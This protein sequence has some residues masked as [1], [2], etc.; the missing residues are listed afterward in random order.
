M[1][2]S[3]YSTSTHTRRIY[4][5]VRL[6]DPIICTRDVLGSV[7]EISVG[8]LVGRLAMPRLLEW[9]TPPTNLFQVR[10][11][12]PLDANLWQQLGDDKW[13]QPVSYP[14]SI[15]RVERLLLFFDV[16]TSEVAGTGSRVFRGFNRW[17]S[18]FVDYFELVTKQ[19]RVQRVKVHYQSNDLELFCWGAEG[20]AEHL[21]DADPIRISA[22]L[23]AGEDALTADQ[24]ARICK[25]SSSDK[26]PELEYRVQLGSY[27][28]LGVGDFRKSI[29]ETAV[30]AEIALTKAIQVRLLEDKISY[31]EKL[32]SKFRML[33]G[34]I[35]LAKTIGI[36]LPEDLKANLVDPR[37]QV[38]HQ[39]EFANFKTAIQAIN[40]TDGILSLQ[41][42]AL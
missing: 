12:P 40:A 10:L 38:I 19:K 5:L 13:G 16:S 35:E 21:R 6:D 20:K 11:L 8:G 23:S 26:E 34:R 3:D 25:L 37:N 7:T 9:T 24:L 28:A 36:S 14:S 15:S 1:H 29:I 33:G 17:R 32:L 27:R 41:S 22:M 2:T 30:A 39:A 18:L 4:G 42:N 31:A